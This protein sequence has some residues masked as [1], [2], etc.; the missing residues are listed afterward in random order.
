MET[1]ELGG[2]ELVRLE[3]GY[4][5]DEET[6]VVKP[7]DLGMVFQNNFKFIIL[8]YIDHFSMFFCYLTQ[9]NQSLAEPDGNN[10]DSNSGYNKMYPA[11]RE[12]D[13]FLPIANIAKIM[14][15]AIPEKGKVTFDTFHS[16]VILLKKI[17]IFFVITNI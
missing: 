8:W 1:D 12:Q 6:Y 4:I 13:R 10:S 16:A 5:V 7:D 14:K 17:S 2:V 3:N 15:R 11:L 9:N